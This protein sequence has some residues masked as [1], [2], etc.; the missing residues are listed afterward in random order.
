MGE[1]LEIGSV[2]VE[3]EHRGNGYF[4]LFIEEF[5]R[6][7]KEANR[8]IYV[9]SVLNTELVR[10][11]VKRGYQLVASSVSPSFVK[12]MTDEAV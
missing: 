4:T 8:C 7:A 6:I 1:T 10:F 11:F 2:E 12:E 9:E 3:E 5:E